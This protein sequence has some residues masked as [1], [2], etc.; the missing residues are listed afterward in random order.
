MPYWLQAYFDFS[1]HTQPKLINPR[2]A[3]YTEETLER[4]GYFFFI[5]DSLVLAELCWILTDSMWSH[6]AILIRHSIPH[7]LQDF[8]YL[9]YSII[10]D[11][12]PSKIK[13]SG[14]TLEYVQSL[15]LGCSL[16]LNKKHPCNECKRTGEG[17]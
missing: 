10:T 14:K 6:L 3:N 8:H 2:S 15:Q 11:N 7:I 9:G 12:K 13:N 5:Q 1:H 16:L 4:S 17:R